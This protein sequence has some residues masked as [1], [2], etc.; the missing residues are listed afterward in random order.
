MTEP[1]DAR[2]VAILLKG[3]PRLS[4]TFIAQEILG[5]E[6][7]GLP[8]LLYSMRRPHDGKV[9]PVHREIRAP[10]SYLPE[11]LHEE[12]LRVLAGLGRALAMPG[13][14]RALW[15][16]LADLR[17]DPTRNRI[18]RLGQ[19][20][21]LAAE[22]PGD[23]GRIHVHFL[24][25]P[26]SVGRYAA[27]MRRPPWSC[28]AHA[29]DIY[30]TPD[31]EKAEKLAD[32]DWLVTCTA[33]NAEVLRRVGGAQGGKV[34]L[35]Y[36]GL[37]LARFPPPPKGPAAS[38]RRDGAV[39]ILSVGRAVAKKGYPVLIEA[40]A[41]LPAEPPWTFTH[42][43]AG[44]EAEA[45]KALATSRGIADRVRFLGAMAQ[46]EVLAQYRQADIFALASRIAADGDRD[47]LPNVLMEAQSQ[48]LAAVS[49]R[50]SAIPELIED[51]VTGLIVPPDDPDALASA[52]A[53]LIGDRALRARL[54]AA[55]AARVRERFTFEAGLALLAKR[56]GLAA[57]GE[58][59]GASAGEGVE[60]SRSGAAAATGE[61]NA[62]CVSCAAERA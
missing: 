23:I 27:V 2:R 12:P 51:D 47:G 42:V 17:R 29:K 36:H 8:V 11:Y 38:E 52:L 56:F 6:R 30:T 55:G 19:A 13:F 26:A 53:R 7:L 41:R 58:D 48:G 49:T 37:D 59:G 4:E 43:G 20:A 39:R 24:H 22:M 21:V 50:V 61:T 10:V 14:W 28:S 44:A 34:S 32:L 18:R 62:D 15:L 57:P 46:D 1:A 35:V 40:L 45:L 60:T 16:F 5:L 54:G 25:T 31:W 3:Y 33:A 9:H